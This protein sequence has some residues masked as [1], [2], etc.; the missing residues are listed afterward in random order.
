MSNRIRVAAQSTTVQAFKEEAGR[1]RLDL[2]DLMKHDFLRS[3]PSAPYGKELLANFVHGGC[4]CGKI[5]PMRSYLDQAVEAIRAQVG[6][7][8][9]ILGLSGG[10]DSSVAAALLQKPGGDQLTGSFANNGRLRSREAEVV[11]EVFGRNFKRQLQYGCRWCAVAA[12]F[13]RAH[14]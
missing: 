9:V 10:G 2:T 13:G 4:G 5:W 6:G 7:E 11:P 12:S 3:I 8:R 14:P 1:Y